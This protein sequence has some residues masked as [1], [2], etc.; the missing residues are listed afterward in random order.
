PVECQLSNNG[1]LAETVVPYLST[2]RQ[3][4]QGDGEVEACRLL[5]KFGR[6]EIDDNAILRPNEAAVDDRTLD[7]VGALTDGCL[8]KADENGFWHGGGR[9]VDLR[10]N[11]QGLDSD[12]T[13][14][15]ESS[16]HVSFATLG[17]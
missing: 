17:S 15:S 12:Q 16:E 6:G 3:H 7:A 13:V 11:W 10:D 2:A 4:P 9:Q 1:V 5:G 14:S 8:R